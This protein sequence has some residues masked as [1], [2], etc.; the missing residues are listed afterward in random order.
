MLLQ[1][2]ENSGTAISEQQAT[3]SAVLCPL[4]RK[5]W[6]SLQIVGI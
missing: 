5:I 6:T 2:K 3:L 4:W 1:M